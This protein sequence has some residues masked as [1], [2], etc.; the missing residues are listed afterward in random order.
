[1]NAFRA[2]RV[3]HSRHS[4]KRP[5]YIFYA[6]RF[7]NSRRLESARNVRTRCLNQSVWNEL[8]ERSY[9][10]LRAPYPARALGLDRSPRS[11]K[12]SHNL[13]LTI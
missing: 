11:L 7:L 13:Y 1:M 6:P 5:D 3:P 12:G 8:T 10:V 4:C 9:S 2:L